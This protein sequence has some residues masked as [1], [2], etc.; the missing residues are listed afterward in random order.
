MRNAR[1]RFALDENGT[2][3]DYVTSQNHPPHGVLQVEGGEWDLAKVAG[4]INRNEHI[5]S[6][7]T[8]T[9]CAE[10]DKVEQAKQDFLSAPT[11]TAPPQEVEQPEPPAEVAATDDELLSQLEIEATDPSTE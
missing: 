11:E 1:S 3:F 5:E 7:Y 2:V 9:A 10:G 8:P 4:L 6:A